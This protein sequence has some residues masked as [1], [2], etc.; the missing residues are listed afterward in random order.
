[1]G[2]HVAGFWPVLNQG[3]TAALFC[4]LFLYFSAA[5]PGAFGVS[6]IARRW[7]VREVG[8]G[9]GHHEPLRHT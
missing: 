2:I 5:G 4:F 1:M 3:S 6:S 7:K 9:A 8:F